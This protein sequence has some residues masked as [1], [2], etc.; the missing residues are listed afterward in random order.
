MYGEL[1]PGRGSRHIV[2][3]TFTF[4]F[5]DIYTTIP[6]SCDNNRR[7]RAQQNNNFDAAADGLSSI[8]A[9]E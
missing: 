2:S 3:G 7:R 8:L 9:I 4:S 1:L 5:L 6:F